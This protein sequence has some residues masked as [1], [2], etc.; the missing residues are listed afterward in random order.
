MN[1]EILKA[2]MTKAHN[3]ALARAFNCKCEGWT[4]IWIWF[5]QTIVKELIEENN[6]DIIKDEP[7][8]S[9]A[10]GSFDIC[11]E[12]AAIVLNGTWIYVICD[13]CKVKD[14]SDSYDICI[15][16]RCSTRWSWCWDLDAERCP[17]CKSTDFTC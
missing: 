16:Q 8:E 9:I 17:K 14:T 2:L 5:V 3:K 12:C 10:L 7:K 1:E 4:A 13:S 15:C 11:K 6:L